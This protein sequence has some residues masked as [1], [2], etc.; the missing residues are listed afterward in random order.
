M[1]FLDGFLH[2]LHGHLLS[3]DQVLSSCLSDPIRLY[4]Y[5]GI[6]DLLPS[7]L[8][9]GLKHLFYRKVS[10]HGVERMSRNVAAITQTLTSI[11][12]KEKINAEKCDKARN[13]FRLLL[14]SETGDTILV[15]L[16]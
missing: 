5:E 16:T 8:M 15:V 9:K 14:L 11:G 3:I 1:C 2:E 7:L 4:L 12:M 10:S 6:Q 13:Y